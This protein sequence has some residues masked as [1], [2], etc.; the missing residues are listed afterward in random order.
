MLKY[1]KITVWSNNCKV[2]NNFRGEKKSGKKKYIYASDKIT[3]QGQVSSADFVDITSVF[4]LDFL[5][6]NA[7]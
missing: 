3:A 4:G 1:S 7:L 6:I 5:I 2:W